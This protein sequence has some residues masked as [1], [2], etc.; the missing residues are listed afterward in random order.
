MF[1]KIGVWNKVFCHT[2]AWLLTAAVG[3]A[4]VM[5]RAADVEAPGDK[6]VPVRALL[7]R[8]EEL[9]ASQK[10]MQQ[11]IDQLKGP[12]LSQ[13]VAQ[14]V[15]Q[16][17]PVVEQVSSDVPGD[18]PDDTH[19]TSLGPL[20]LQAFSDF[21]FGRPWFENLPPRGLSG[22]TNSFTVGD[23]DLFTNTR[24]S[25]HLNV[26]GELLVTSD[27]DNATSIE[28]DRLLLTYKAN[29]YFQVSFG[30]YNTAIGYYTN[31]FHRAHFFQTAISRPIMF[32]DEDN[33]G[34]LPVH[35][36]GLTA[37]GKIPSGSA[38]LNWVAEIANGRSETASEPIQ[39][40]SDENNGKA[41]NFALYTRPAWLPGFQAGASFYVDTIH[42]IAAPAMRET[43][44]AAYVV[45]VSPKLEW[46]NEMAVVTHSVLDSSRV[47]HALT[48][49]SQ[50]S[51]GFGRTRP[52]FRYDYQNAASSDPIFGIL[53]RENG[54]SVGV[55][56]RLS[57]FLIIKGQYGWLTLE[58]H[59]TGAVDGQLAFAF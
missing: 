3:F 32:A 37:T 48:S 40:F 57:T 10:Q 55:E 41:V 38:G 49:Y 30:K 28:I 25:D 47:Y 31:A 6:D 16:P 35:N 33:N 50:I 23:F 7:K 11:T 21:E 54:P 14:P 20:K 29:D 53:G 36:I 12:T 19:V 56:R 52:Y 17:T 39:N 8:I 45:Y 5:A 27:F 26:L 15:P 43:I 58:N 18:A 2:V 44:P 13:P 34:I 9:E 24:I 51:W 22:T 59:T 46:L 4:P 42:P 1:I